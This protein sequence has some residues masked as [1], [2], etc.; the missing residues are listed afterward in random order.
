M[1]N[2]F[3]LKQFLVEGKLLNEIKVKK[4]GGDLSNP[5][6]LKRVLNKIPSEKYFYIA[7]EQADTFFDPEENGPD[8][9]WTEFDDFDGDLVDYFYDDIFDNELKGKPG[10][11][12]G[13]FYEWREIDRKKD[14]TEEGY[15]GKGEIM[16]Y[17]KIKD[18]ITAYKKK[19]FSNKI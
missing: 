15:S 10:I 13:D 2:N 4:P 5:I 12:G 14:N 19:H 7:D 11:I 17:N 3:N 8:Y 9:N 1:N 18:I 6:N 16:L